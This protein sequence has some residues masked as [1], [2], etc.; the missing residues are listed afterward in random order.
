MGAWGVAP[1]RQGG[2]KACSSAEG[3]VSFK[4]TQETGLHQLQQRQRLFCSALPRLQG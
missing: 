2:Q 3:H 4:E 1:F